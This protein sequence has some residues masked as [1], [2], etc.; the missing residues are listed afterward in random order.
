[1][2]MPAGIL[3]RICTLPNEVMRVQLN[4]S[5]LPRY[6]PLCG[7]KPESLDR[8]MFVNIPKWRSFTETTC[9]VYI[10][11]GPNGSKFFSPEIKE[12]IV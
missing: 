1:M 5:I 6:T 2:K 4:S 8:S 12:D 10:S 9:R 7:N 11:I 3:G